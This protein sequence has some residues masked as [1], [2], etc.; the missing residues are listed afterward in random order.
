MFK[1]FQ[2]KI[3]IYS[4]NTLTS[5]SLWMKNQ[6]LLH[7]ELIYGLPSILSGLILDELSINIKSQAAEFRINRIYFSFDVNHF[8]FDRLLEIG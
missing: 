3:H 2:S 4:R 8:L 6:I 1:R 7:L 5:V